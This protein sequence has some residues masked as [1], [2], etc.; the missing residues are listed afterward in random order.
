MMIDYEKIA[1]KIDSRFLLHMDGNF[2]DFLFPDPNQNGNIVL[3][4]RENAIVVW[5]NEYRTKTQIEVLS[6]LALK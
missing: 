6:I 2:I 4:Q 1:K 3:E 5:S